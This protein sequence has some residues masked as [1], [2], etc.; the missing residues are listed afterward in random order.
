MGL[1]T[2]KKPTRYDH[3]GLPAKTLRKV[4]KR[5]NDSSMLDLNVGAWTL[6]R[7]S[8]IAA[9]E[10]FV[11]LMAEKGVSEADFGRHKGQE[12]IVLAKTE[13]DFRRDAEGN[14]GPHKKSIW[15]NYRDTEE[16]RAYRREMEHLNDFLD[17]ADIEFIPDGLLPKVCPSERTLRRYFSCAVRPRKD[18]FQRNGRIFGGFWLNLKK[19]RR[20]NIRISGEPV[21]LLDF[22]SM[23]VRLAYATVGQEPPQGDLYDLS[24]VLKG[25][26]NEEHRDGVKQ[27]FNS[28]LNG[29]R[30]GHKDIL[31]QLPPHTKAKAFRDAVS[32]RHPAL[33]PLFGGTAIGLNLMFAESRI[34]S[35][36]ARSAHAEGGG[37]PWASRWLACGLV[38]G[39][40]G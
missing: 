28:L 8:T 19:G 22:S 24:G 32:T 31:K 39:R 30:A 2:G 27:G 21:A 36:H 40:G 33:I 26:D 6:R 29:G 16:T 35:Q 9:T 4:V 12:L 13:R 18:A 5:L 38:S 23:F 37:W 14:Y 20:K 7:T 15:V 10:W 34:L 1:A 3:R 25:Y 17:Q 11:R